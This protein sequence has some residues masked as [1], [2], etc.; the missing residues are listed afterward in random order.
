MGTEMQE[1]GSCNDQSTCLGGIF[2][3]KYNYTFTYDCCDYNLCNTLDY[4]K[5]LNYKCEFHKTV[6]KTKKLTF[7]V[8]N[9]KAP[10][11]KQCYYCNGCS[12]SKSAKVV[13]CV[14]RNATI[15][16]FACIVISR[17]IFHF[18]L[19]LKKYIFF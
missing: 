11:V 14:E 8:R 1:A 13:N 12:T 18:Y 10:S 9:A 6:P 19:K 5:T 2:I 7:P 16:N 17:L 4:G 3:V 15:K